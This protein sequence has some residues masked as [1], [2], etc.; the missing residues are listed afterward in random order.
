[1]SPFSFTSSVKKL[2]NNKK[3]NDSTN[4]KL[5]PLVLPQIVAKRDSM[6]SLNI[7]R[8]ALK[9]LLLPARVASRES[10]TKDEKKPNAWARLLKVLLI[11]SYTFLASD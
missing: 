4:S 10:T 8:P 5:R 7:K 9:P 6:E 11:R 3:G 1:M 2:V